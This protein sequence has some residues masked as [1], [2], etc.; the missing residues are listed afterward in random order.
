MTTRPIILLI[1]P[2]LEVGELL[3]T[4]LTPYETVQVADRNDAFQFLLKNQVDLILLEVDLPGVSG[5]QL[6]RE[7]F[8][9]PL[10]QETPIIMISTREQK[11]DI[12]LG[13]SSGADDYVVKPFDLIELSYRIEAR[14]RRRRLHSKT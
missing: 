11:S 14:L 10:Y 6:C 7:I 3:K 4:S 1:D 13:L 2:D 9:H 12:A 5:F 8:N